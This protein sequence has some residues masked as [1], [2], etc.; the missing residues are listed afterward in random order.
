MCASPWSPN[1]IAVLDNR[2]TR[3]FGS[4]DG[5]RL[6]EQRIAYRTTARSHQPVGP[7]GFMS[8]RLTGEPFNTIA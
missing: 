3:H 1:S 2:A 7:G 5:T 8:R 6:K 4:I